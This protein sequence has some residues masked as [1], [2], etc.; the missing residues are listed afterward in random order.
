MSHIHRDHN[1]RKE[2]DDFG[3]KIILPDTTF[4]VA[5]APDARLDPQYIPWETA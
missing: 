5:A 1:L 2:S 3:E 4:G